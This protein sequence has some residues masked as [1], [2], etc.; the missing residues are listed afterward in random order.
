MGLWCWPGKTTGTLYVTQKHSRGGQQDQ[1]RL[2]K[3]ISDMVAFH[4]VWPF[5][6][7]R[8]CQY[9]WFILEFRR[10]SSIL[11]MEKGA[12][13]GI[14]WSMLP[15]EADVQKIVQFNKSQWLVLGWENGPNR[16]ENAQSGRSKRSY[17][18]SSLAWE[19]GLSSSINRLRERAKRNTRGE[20]QM[21][22]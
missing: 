10:P 3:N 19:A 18:I 9:L 6:G 21:S 14:Q 8:I 1:W 4:Q 16:H 12:G 13:A 22:S 17:R 15:W 11:W 5:R 7:L 2:D 20:K